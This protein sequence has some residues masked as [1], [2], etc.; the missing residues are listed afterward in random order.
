MTHS[1]GRF[2]QVENLDASGM[3]S[4]TTYAPARIVVLGVMKAIFGVLVLGLGAIAIWAT[5]AGDMAPKQPGDM[6]SWWMMLVG[7]VLAFVGFTILC[8]GVGRMVSAFA[9]DCYFRAGPQGI[10]IRVPKQG[11]F[12]R[13]QLAEYRFR[14]EE[15]KQLVHFTHRINLIPVSRELRIEPQAGKT[16]SI[17]RFYFSA[18]VKNIQ[19]Q[20]S[21]IQA[22]VGR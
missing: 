10:A 14:W 2:Q 22:S 19:Q 3:Q 17:P 8:G 11:W 21:T 12:G 15:I 9:R 5:A 7:A 16:I 4:V 20:L 18:S 13:F 6:P 1:N